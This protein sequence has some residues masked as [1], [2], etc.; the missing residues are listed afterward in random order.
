MRRALALVL[1]AALVVAGGI[2]TGVALLAEEDTAAEARA[3]RLAAV[4]I[5]AS[6]PRDDLVALAEVTDAVTFGDGEVIFREGDPGGTLYVIDA[7]AVRISTGST[8]L[9]TLGAGEV[10]GELSLF[11][12]DTRSA[13]ATADSAVTLL[14]IAHDDFTPFLESRPTVGIA[15]LDTLADRLRRTNADLAACQAGDA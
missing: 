14:A 7:G 4:S 3:D 9:A 6:L 1:L 8:T 2:V 12:S 11:G 10:F 13:D 15:L 5:F